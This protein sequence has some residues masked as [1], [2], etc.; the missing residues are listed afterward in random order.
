MS[1]DEFVLGMRKFRSDMRE[2]VEQCLDACN[3]DV[4]IAPGDS[5]LTTVAMGAGYPI[6][7]VPLGFADLNGRPYGLLIMGRSGEEAKIL[8]VMAAWETTFC[9]GRKPP[10][11]MQEW[12]NER[13]PL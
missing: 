11:L 7:S 13:C 10:S 4:I 3:A 6:A 12:D 2:A 1:D 9:E 5:L 8:D